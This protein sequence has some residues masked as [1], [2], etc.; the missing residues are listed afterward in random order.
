[1]SEL[2]RHAGTQII[3]RTFLR[4]I[5]VLDSSRLHAVDCSNISAEVCDQGAAS[6]HN[7]G[8]K[9]ATVGWG[10]YFRSCQLTAP[11]R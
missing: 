8:R 7:A 4:A 9:V 11:G 6:L 2:A 10:E 3:P 1:M 5:A